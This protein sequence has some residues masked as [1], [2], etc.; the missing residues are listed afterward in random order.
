MKSSIS[1]RIPGP[2]SSNLHHSA[3][4]DVIHTPVPT[5]SRLRLAPGR[6]DRRRDRRLRTRHARGPVARKDARKGDAP[7]AAP[8]RAAP[9][10]VG[11]KHVAGGGGFGFAEYTQKKHTEKIAF[12]GEKM[13]AR[14]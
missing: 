2:T 13:A 8:G 10:H 5:P 11:N 6:R 1:H 7:L 4:P 3:R 14:G 12:N 9:G